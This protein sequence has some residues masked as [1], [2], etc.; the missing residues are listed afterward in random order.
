MR[1]GNT[2]FEP[3]LVYQRIQGLGSGSAGRH[4]AINPTWRTVELRYG[5]E[6]FLMTSLETFPKLAMCLKTSALYTIISL[7]LKQVW[8]GF[9]AFVKG[10]SWGL[11]SWFLLPISP[12]LFRDFKRHLPFMPYIKDFVFALFGRVYSLCPN[13]CSPFLSCRKLG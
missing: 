13:I 2:E 6:C 4:L 11:L 7:L 9:T 12:F 8:L 1:L 5:K 3:L 10:D